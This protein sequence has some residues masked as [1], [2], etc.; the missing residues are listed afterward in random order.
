MSSDKNFA[1]R[2]KQADKLDQL[3]ERNQSVFTIL[4]ELKENGKEFKINTNHLLKESMSISEQSGLLLNK[5]NIHYG[6]L[7]GIKRQVDDLSRTL[8]ELCRNLEVLRQFNYQNHQKTPGAYGVAV[9]SELHSSSHQNS[10][11]IV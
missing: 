10:R 2:N 1:T 5:E 7:A 11:S 6:E 9:S 4:E 8:P 3:L